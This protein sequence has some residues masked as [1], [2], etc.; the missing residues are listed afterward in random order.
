[1]NRTIF[2]NV[3]ELTYIATQGNA[4]ATSLG[5]RNALIRTWE[6]ALFTFEV[7]ALRAST[8]TI[9][10]AAVGSEAAFVVDKSSESELTAESYL[11]RGRFDRQISERMFWF[12]GLGWDR[13]FKRIAREVGVT[14]LRRPSLAGAPICTPAERISGPAL[15]AVQIRSRR[16]CRTQMGS[17]LPDQFQK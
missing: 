5:L 2:L 4:E 6:E 3:S 12:A 9:Q 16:I 7:A 10:R 8:G 14:G 1:M 17:Q 13:N 11:A 15:R